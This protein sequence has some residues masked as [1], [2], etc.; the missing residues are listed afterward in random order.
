M[1]PHGQFETSVDAGSNE[2]ALKRVE[3]G[4]GRVRSLSACSLAAVLLVFFAALLALPLQAQAQ[5]CETGDI[6]CATM[7]VGQLSAAGITYGYGYDSVNSQGSLSDD[8]FTYGSAMT[9]YTVRRIYITTSSNPPLRIEFSPSGEMVFDTDDFFLYIDGTAFPFSSATFISGDQFQW[10]D[11]GL[12][13]SIGDTVEV[14]LVEQSGTAAT[15]KPTISGT[16]R[17]GQTLTADTS[18]IADADGLTSVSYSYQ[19]IRVQDLLQTE[20]SGAT[21]STYTP[22]ADDVGKTIRV[23]VTF[24]DDAGNPENSTSDAYPSSGTVEAPPPVPPRTLPAGRR[25]GRA[26]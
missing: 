4:R 12:S 6:W 19:W 2:T 26:R 1:Q 18:G 11:T 21:A 15:G 16:A 3:P 13:W 23:K 7:T 5:T 14:R 20:I 9:A 8:G 17:V 25:S 24:S 22:V 10:T